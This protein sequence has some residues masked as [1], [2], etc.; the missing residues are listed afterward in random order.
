MP[1]LALRNQDTVYVINSENRL[2]IRTVKV[3]STSEDQVMVISGVSHGEQVVTSTLPNAS[4]G[5]AVEPVFREAQ[6]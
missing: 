6:G 3:L 1:R 5:M 4:D 2:E